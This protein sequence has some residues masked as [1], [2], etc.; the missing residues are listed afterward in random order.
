MRRFTQKKKLHP[1]IGI[2]SSPMPKAHLHRAA[3]Y[4]E[5]AYVRWVELSGASAVII[6]YNT[7]N[8]QR[9]LGS[10]DSVIF[11]G[12]AIEN[13][14]T[15]SA[16][17]YRQYMRVFRTIYEHAVRRNNFPLWGTCQGF[18]LLA[19]MGD[20]PKANH[21]YDTMQAVPKHGLATIAFRGPS[22]FRRLFTAAERGR[23]EA[24]PSCSHAHRWGFRTDSD[25]ARKM[26]SYLDVVSTDRTDDG[27]AEFIN[28]FAYKNK[29]FYGSIWHVER[30][31]NELSEM[32]AQRFSDFLRKEAEKGG[33]Q[34]P[35]KPWRTTIRVPLSSAETVL[36]T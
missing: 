27:T 13:E 1:K 16:A 21:F 24:V 5:R 3:S 6:P 7:K 36:L 20:P 2:L 19:L 26:Q 11:C 12:G 35:N 33:C 32:T 17:Q 10:V 15:H 4:V 18:E 8:L 25:V 31:T 30:T 28:M 34:R 23:L 14:A 22:Q 29:P 9:Y